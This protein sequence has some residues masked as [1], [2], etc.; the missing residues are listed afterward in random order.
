MKFILNG[1]EEGEVASA[2]ITEDALSV[3]LKGDFPPPDPKPDPT[4]DP[5]PEPKPDPEPTPVPHNVKLVYPID[6]PGQGL[7]TLY[8]PE[9]TIFSSSFTIPKSGQGIAYFMVED[10][11][12]VGID[13]WI[14]KTPGGKALEGNSGLYGRGLMADIGVTWGM[15]YRRLIELEYGQT[16][17]INCKSS[18]GKRAL[19]YRTVS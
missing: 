7:V 14:S 5:E 16:Y 15:T 8:I 2:T 19:F 1:K 11:S 17:Y 13:L 18:T 9:K 12:G 10:R 6:F 3:I 4:P